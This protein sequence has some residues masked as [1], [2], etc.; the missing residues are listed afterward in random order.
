MRISP[1]HTFALSALLLGSP[2]CA[3]DRVAADP[4]ASGPGAKPGQAGPAD[5]PQATPGT[6]TT[7]AP[8]APA[9]PA[10]PP[11][12]PIDPNAAVAKVN[13]VV[14]TSKNYQEAIREFL[15]GQGAPPNLPEAQMGQVRQAV[16][17][18][19]IGT[20]LVFQKSQAE[21]IKVSQQE[22][23]E[24]LAETKKQFPDE[25][26]WEASLKLQGTDKASFLEAV[27]RNLAINKAIKADVFDKIAVT[28][29]DA[30][31]Y[32][33]LHPQ[34]MQKPEEV[35]ASHIL[36]RVPEGATDEAKKTARAKADT[37]LGK[38][39]A[40]GDFAALAKEYSDDTGSAVQGGDLGFFG[41]GRM[42]PAFETAVFA[43]KI[44]QVSEVVESQFG[45]HVIK[46]IDRHDAQTAP[47]E[48]ITGKLKDFLKQK[49][50]RTDVQAYLKSL[51]DVAKV[52][53]F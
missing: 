5:A 46:L 29:A 25:E 53:V 20:E 48:E 23:D 1:L 7:T 36:V 19:L 39:K 28:D 4:N 33:D 38:V 49:R 24:A 32:Y 2:A 13:G 45:F 27:N 40:G 47:F 15:Q 51:R 52:E 21:G 30:K 43:M 8:G 14:I 44:G 50:A 6:A 16:M 26:K 10:A 31:A 37:A 18:A 41:R 11:A 9:P 35:R 42:V 3:G 12:I 34:E 17:E 22:I